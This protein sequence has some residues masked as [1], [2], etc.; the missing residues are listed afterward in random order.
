MATTPNINNFQ[1]FDGKLP[2]E[3]YARMLCYGHTGAGKTTFGA[4]MPGP[5]A[6]LAVDANA[7]P[8]LRV[9]FSQ[10][11]RTFIPPG[12]T[13]REPEIMLKAANWD[14]IQ[15]AAE[16]LLREVPKRGI[17][18]VII[19][20]L[21]SIFDKVYQETLEDRGEQYI[22][23]QVR[24]GAKQTRSLETLDE[25]GWGILGTRMGTLRHILN[26]IP[27]HLLYLAHCKPPQVKTEQKG[28]STQRTVTEQGTVDISGRSSRLF[29]RDVGAVLYL[30][31][32]DTT[33]GTIV[34]VRTRPNGEYYAKDNT[35]RLDTVEPP[36]AVVIL[37]RMGVLAPTLADKALAAAPKRTAEDRQN[38]EL[39]VLD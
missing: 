12:E 9:P 11:A 3:E 37:A 5:R 6:V 21:T 18:S 2:E 36:D 27:A 30:E 14:Q 26:Q 1:F 22:Q 19:D 33:T 8:P 31:R 4:T 17:V 32:R 16:F 35:G 29:L 24:S 10:L 28:G 34:R 25:N 39:G 38:E 15:A 23:N 20:S 13:D 7:V